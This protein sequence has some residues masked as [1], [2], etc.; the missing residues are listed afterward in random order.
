M[1]KS[2]LMNEQQ[3]NDLFQAIVTAF[4]HAR[5]ELDYTNPF[6][7]M[8]AIILSAQ[9]TDKGVN[10]ATPALFAKADTPQKML[11]LGADGVREHVKSLNYFNNKTKSIIGLSQTLVD[12]FNGVL[13]STFDELITLPGVGR[14]TANVFLNVLYRAPTIGVDTHVFRLAHRLKITTG[15]TPEE[16]EKNLT[17]LVPDVYKPDIALST[18][19]LGRYICT[20]KKPKCAECPVFDFCHADEKKLSI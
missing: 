2:D 11:D 10:K 17:P 7:L 19:L 4:P 5:C 13:P 14:K 15:K 16:V 9:S 3:R 6:T 12:K 8:V 20:A 18:V 1:A